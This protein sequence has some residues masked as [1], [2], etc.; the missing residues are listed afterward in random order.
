MDINDIFVVY[1]L[2]GRE[3]ENMCEEMVWKI[4]DF[5]NF[6]IKNDIDLG[7]VVFVVVV[8][9]DYLERIIGLRVEFFMI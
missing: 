2:I 9:I 3:D 4:V 6:F 8:F 5:I 7:L 1:K